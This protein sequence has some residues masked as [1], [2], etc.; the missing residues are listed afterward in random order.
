M[1]IPKEM[2]R[3]LDWLQRRQ[4]ELGGHLRPIGVLGHDRESQEGLQKWAKDRP[5]I[6]NLKGHKVRTVMDSNG[7]AMLGSK[8]KG[9]HEHPLIVISQRGI[10]EQSMLYRFPWRWG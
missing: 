6:G 9:G 7:M 4:L 10:V 2:P 3:I 5:G 8:G 1:K